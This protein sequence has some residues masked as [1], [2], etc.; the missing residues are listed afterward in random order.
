MKKHN[1][2]KPMTGNQSSKVLKRT[3]CKQKRKEKK[4]A[5]QQTT[6]INMDRIWSALLVRMKNGS[7]EI[8]H[9]KFEIKNQF[10]K[11]LPK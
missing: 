7:T 3:K 9:K 2:G 1:D 5:L 6:S 10:F 11:Q 4:K 8:A